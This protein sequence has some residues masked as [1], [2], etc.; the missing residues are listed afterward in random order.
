MMRV[1]SYTVKSSLGLGEI[2]L[3]TGEIQSRIG[4]NHPF[5]V[6]MVSLRDENK[7]A[8]CIGGTPYLI[9]VKYLDR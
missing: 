3:S 6:D 8:Y 5:G 7:R 4:Q 9:Y 1:H 2:C